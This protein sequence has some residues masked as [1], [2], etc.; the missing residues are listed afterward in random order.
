MDKIGLKFGFIGLGQ[1]GGNIANEFAALGYKAI[2]VNTSSTDLELLD[3]I[4]KNYRMLI[5]VGIQGAGK[6]PDVGREALETRI[7][8]VWELVTTVF[9]D[10][11]KIFLCAGLGGG[12]GSGM[13]PLMA[14]ILCEQ[15]LEVGVIT[16]FPSDIESARVKVVALSTFQKLTEIEGVTSIFAIDNKKASE[17]LPGVGMSSKY[18]LLNRKMSTHLDSI[19]KLSI[20]PS[21]LAFDAKD[22]EVALKTRGIALINE[23]IIEDIN[24]LKD[25]LTLG[26]LLKTAMETSLGPNYDKIEAGAAVFLFELPEGRGRYITERSMKII[27]ERAGNPFDVFYGIYENQAE[28]TSGVLT[29]MLGG[30]SVMDIPRLMEMNDEIEEKGRDIEK[31]FS[32]QKESYV[33]NAEGLLNKI[34]RKPDTIKK[35]YNAGVSNSVLDRLR[36]TNKK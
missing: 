12:T 30:L 18:K 8:E 5:N 14:E 32:K 11:D 36:A 20:Q 4:G 6:N 25:D 7:D 29:I 3:N 23:I 10:I 34:N 33:S 2:A 22:L 15:G 13:L 9:D 17:R 28:K 1:A 19:N 35:G 31:M 21:L 24:D 26:N 27:N 16:T